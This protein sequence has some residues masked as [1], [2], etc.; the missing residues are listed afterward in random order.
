M[1]ERALTLF[2]QKFSLQ[3]TQTFDTGLSDFHH[4]ISTELKSTYSKLPPR[5]VRYRSYK[6]FNES[7]FLKDLSNSLSK[8]IDSDLNYDIFESVFE[9][10]LDRHV[11]M[12]FKVYSR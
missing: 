5:K 9:Y 11:P 7:F 2:S 4:L 6:N 1:Y 8:F 12:K 3:H 10:V